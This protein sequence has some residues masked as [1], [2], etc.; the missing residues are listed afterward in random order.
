MNTSKRHIMKRIVAGTLACAVMLMT[1]SQ[2]AS[3]HKLEY[4]P[5]VTQHYYYQQGRRYAFPRWLR[6]DKGFQRWYLRS[7]YRYIRG[8]SWEGLYDLY[9]YERK[10][11]RYGHRHFKGRVYV[12]Y[13]RPYRRR[14]R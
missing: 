11:R 4:R 10:L 9:R 8:A 1:F 7:N 2:P 5:Y 6:K 14:H 3:A 13:D 12:D